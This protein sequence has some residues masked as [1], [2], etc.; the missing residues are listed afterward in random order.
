MKKNIIGFGVGILLVLAGVA[1]TSMKE[2]LAGSVVL[3]LG[4][5]TELFFLVKIMRRVWQN[6]NEIKK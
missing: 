6:R 5:M 4:M 2:N 3:T 1:L